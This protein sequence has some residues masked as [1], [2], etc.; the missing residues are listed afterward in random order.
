MEELPKPLH[1]KAMVGRH[2]ANLK[3]NGMVCPI[4][5]LSQRQG[6]RSGIQNQQFGIQTGIQD[7][8]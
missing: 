6:Y 1:N 8:L 5:D 3:I 4:W 2:Q 7:G